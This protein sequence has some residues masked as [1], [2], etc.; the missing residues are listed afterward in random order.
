MGEAAAL[1]AAQ[2]VGRAP[3]LCLVFVGY[4]KKSDSTA[5][6]NLEESLVCIYCPGAVQDS[7]EEPAGG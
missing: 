4:L 2:W 1:Q 3:P 7:A 6:A 5:K